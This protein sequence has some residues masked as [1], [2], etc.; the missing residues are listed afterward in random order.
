MVLSMRMST[1][2]TSGGGR[3]TPA[4]K[5][6]LCA[7]AFGSLSGSS[8]AFVVPPPS[9]P[10]SFARPLTHGSG[11]YHPM[12]AQPLAHSQHSRLFFSQ[13]DD[14][15][16]DTFKRSGG[17]LLKKGA[18]K[19]KSLIPF[20]KSEEERRA[21]IM[22]KERKEEITGG[23]NTMLKDAP[24]PIR[25]LGRMMSPLLARAADEIAQQTEQAQDMLEEARL[26]LINDP[27]VAEKFGEPLQVGQPFSQSSSTAVINGQRS[28]RVRASFQV[29]GPLGSGIASMESINGEISSLNVNANGRN[30]SVGTSRR[31]KELGKSP[32]S[33]KKYD[34]VIEAEIIEKK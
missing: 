33:G 26:R 16:W 13:K 15:D 19:I 27:M 14:S 12:L 7:A 5:T 32:S 8:W 20:G 2:R 10:V 29:A 21:K 3:R 23:I 25:M 28:A 17:N 31:G 24:L 6:I 34:N 11:N 9:A 4:A 30:L 18:N 22:K 1:S